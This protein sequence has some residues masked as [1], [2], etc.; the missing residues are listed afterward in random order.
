MAETK[1]KPTKKQRKFTKKLNRQKIILSLHENLNFSE[2][3][4]TMVCI[5]NGGL[6]NIVAHEEI[7]EL[8]SENG[9]ECEVIMLP[10][11]AFS[12]VVYGT[13]QEAQLAY[14]ALNGHKLLATE[15][16][17]TNVTL[18]LFFV[19]SVPEYIS[20]S[21]EKPSGLILLEDFITVEY[22]DQ[23]MESVVWDTD[24]IAGQKQY[25]KH[26]KVQHYGYQ[27]KYD[28]NDVDPGIPL[29]EKIPVVYGPLLDK[30][31]SAGLVKYYPDQLTVN[32]YLP[33]QGIP[34][35]VDTT[36]AFEDGI[37]CLSLGSQVLMEF[38]HPD[39]R[40][41][42]V[43]LPPRSVMILSGESRYIWSHGI[44]PRKS[45]IVH[46]SGGDS[47]LTISPRGVRTSFTFRKITGVKPCDVQLHLTSAPQHDAALHLEKH[48]VHQVYE[49]IADHFSRTRHTPWPRIANF[50]QEQN[51][52]S[53]FVDI[54]CGNGK[55]FGINKTLFELGS[56]RSSKLVRI[57]SERNYQVYVGDVLAVPLREGIVDVCL[58]I[59][60]IHHLAT[61]DRRR[62][63]IVELMKIMRPGGRLLIYVWAKEQ[64]VN[65]ELSNYLDRKKHDHCLAQQ[66]LNHP[67]SNNK[68]LGNVIEIVHSKESDTLTSDI[69]QK[70][71]N[72]AHKIDESM[73]LENKCGH[74]HVLKTKCRQ[75]EVNVSVNGDVEQYIKNDSSKID[76]TEDNTAV[77][78][79]PQ[80]LPI[81]VNR[82]PFKHHDVLVPWQMKNTKNN[83][84][85]SSM[86]TFHRF[87]HVFHHGE[88]ESL[89]SS[90]STCR[91]IKGYYDQ[92]NWAVVLEKV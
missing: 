63:A 51:P 75:C 61:E 24:A 56:D 52:G 27:F 89:C 60:V 82:T 66:S 72:N 85:T 47:G 21:I 44:I 29:L 43:V 17:N 87:Y 78:L 90:V 11:K 7:S 28:T 70:L 40:H 16:R 30:I 50:L 23:I 5:A 76:V 4:T 38:K 54:G 79:H 31:L 6:D 62:Q 19:S 59:A 33:G 92:G 36:Y 35:H 91:V 53:L 77:H 37:I 81:H 65:N 74:A 45:D 46:V 69:G 2:C 32:H 22:A 39:G 1:T 14:S 80:I 42:S 15:Y 71:D 18:F 58:C 25:L 73:N 49:E 68:Q 57:C 9:R 13:A 67:P 83:D 26:R 64:E 41:L 88:L 3:P 55:Y 48:H 34:S 86:K 12:F 20:P 8:F 10:Q 84:S